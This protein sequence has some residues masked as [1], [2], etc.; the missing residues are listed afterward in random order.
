MSVFTQ[1]GEWLQKKIGN[2]FFHGETDIS[3]GISMSRCTISLC[4]NYGSAE[5]LMIFVWDFHL[6]N[7]SKTFGEHGKQM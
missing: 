1:G 4:I 2:F 3:L 7:L 6:F 5:V